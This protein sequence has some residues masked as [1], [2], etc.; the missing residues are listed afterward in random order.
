[1]DLVVLKLIPLPFLVFGSETGMHNIQNPEILTVICREFVEK[2]LFTILEE[3]QEATLSYICYEQTAM[4][5]P[6]QLSA[7]LGINIR[8]NM[9]MEVMAERQKD[10]EAWEPS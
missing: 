3:F 2:I 10:T 9:T 1:M 6:L 5:L 7:I 8:R 4:R